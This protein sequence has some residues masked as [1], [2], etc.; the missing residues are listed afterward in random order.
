LLGD[1]FVAVL[2]KNHP[3]AS[4][5]ELSIEMFASMAHLEVSSTIRRLNLSTKSSPSGSLNVEWR[6]ARLS[7]QP[8]R[9]L[10]ASDMI[11][12]LPRRVAEDVA[13]YRPLT[14]RTIAQLTPTIESAMIWLRRFENQ[15]AHRWMRDVVSFVAN[16]FPAE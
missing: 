9:I 10:G 8:V 1:E 13:S 4:G 5:R 6:F 3:A 15:P 11:S 2:R 7:F 12:V 14:I 16:S